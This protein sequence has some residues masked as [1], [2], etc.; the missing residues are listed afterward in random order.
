MGGVNGVVVGRVVGVVM[1]GVFDGRGSMGG[2]GG[3]GK[4]VDKDGEMMEGGKGVR[5]EW[6][7]R[8]LCGVVGGGGGGV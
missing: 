5:S 6:M 1:R 2:V 8:V 4:V 3:E 7:R